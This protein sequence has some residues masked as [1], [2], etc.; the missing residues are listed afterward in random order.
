MRFTTAQ[1]YA[2][3]KFRSIEFDFYTACPNRK[4]ELD[5]FDAVRH[6]RGSFCARGTSV[7]IISRCTYGGITYINSFV[8]MPTKQRPSDARLCDF[9]ISTLLFFSETT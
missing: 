3:H 9:Q 6:L 7:N 4:H 8:L 1:Y 2:L 5:V